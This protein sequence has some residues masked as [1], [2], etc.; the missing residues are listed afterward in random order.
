MLQPR[1]S[2]NRILAHLPQ[3]DLALL[4]PF[5]ELVTLPL[6]RSAPPAH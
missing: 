3:R 2:S 5:L 6:R 1:R 4:E